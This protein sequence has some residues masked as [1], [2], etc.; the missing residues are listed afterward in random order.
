MTS[1]GGVLASLH[2]VYSSFKEG[3]PL[4]NADFVR[5]ILDAVCIGVETLRKSAD[6]IVKS[7]GWWVGAQLRLR[8]PLAAE[9]E[10]E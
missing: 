8:T 5:E 10:A 4:G 2:G 3:V 1:H 9:V 6:L 7:C